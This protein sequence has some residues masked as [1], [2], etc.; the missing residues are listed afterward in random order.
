MVVPFGVSVGD[1]I[2]GIRLFKGAI[3]SFS[4]TRGA[5]ADYIE[6]RKCLGALETSLNSANQ[7]TTPLH[8]ATIKP[9][10]LRS[11]LRKVQWSLCEKEKV[12][13]FRRQLQ[14]YV[15]ILQMN[16]ITFNMQA[17]KIAQ[18]S[19]QIAETRSKAEAS[20]LQVQ[21]RNEIA[22]KDVPSRL[23]KIQE[24][25]ESGLSPEEQHAM[26]RLL[27]EVLAGRRVLQN[28]LE[29]LVAHNKTFESHIIDLKTT[30]QIQ[31]EI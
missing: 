28:Q 19:K 12:L 23:L 9:A 29:T 18:E 4:N 5:R 16:L 7:F 11:G 21:M 20:S 24:R 8:Q 25:L 15:T 10:K 22:M 6:L 14:H 26:F 30:V 31:R 3:E 13:E 27:G 2:A 1:F 17:S